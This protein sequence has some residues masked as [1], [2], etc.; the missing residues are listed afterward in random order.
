MIGTSIFE[1]CTP[2][3][4]LF[5]TKLIFREETVVRC[6]HSVHARGQ[7]AEISTADKK[8][9][10]FLSVYIRH[11]AFQSEVHS[12]RRQLA[13]KSQDAPLCP[14]SLFAAAGGEAR[15]F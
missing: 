10:G 4:G 14:K 6:T 7:T 5:S 3:I 15:S 9:V 11:V 13:R 8:M 2:Y 12:M 1:R